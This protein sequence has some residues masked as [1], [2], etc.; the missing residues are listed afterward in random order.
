ML[1]SLLIFQAIIMQILTQMHQQILAGV[2]IQALT[3][4]AH[5]AALIRA[6]REGQCPAGTKHFE[7]TPGILLGERQFY[8]VEMELCEKGQCTQ[9]N[10]VLSRSSAILKEDIIEHAITVRLS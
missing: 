5:P 1:L 8:S 6:C 10:Q 3:F 9:I 2:Q 4:P 7:E